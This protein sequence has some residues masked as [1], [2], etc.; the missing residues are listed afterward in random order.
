VIGALMLVALLACGEAARA[1]E[2]ARLH[3]IEP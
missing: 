1:I 3:E 2:E